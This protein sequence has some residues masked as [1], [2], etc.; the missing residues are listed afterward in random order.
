MMLSLPLW[1]IVAHFVAD[2][3]CQSDRMATGKSESFV[4]LTE[5]VVLYT[6]MIAS[7]A[8][9]YYLVLERWAFT[10]MF[11]VVT[12]VAH[13][14]TDAVTSRM[15]KRLWIAG[16]RHAF[17]TMIGLDQVLHYVALALA[18]RYWS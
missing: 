9:L 3:L 4:I 2:W 14:L 7:A 12:F 5:H 15:T 6:G 10:P 11:L 18:L 13:W 16:E 1:I 8:C 17:F